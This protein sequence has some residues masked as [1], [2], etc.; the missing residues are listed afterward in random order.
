MSPDRRQDD[1]RQGDRRQGE[2]R[3]EERRKSPET[4]SVS[5]SVFV[6]TII[7]VIIVFSISLAL[8]LSHYENTITELKMQLLP[9]LTIVDDTT[10]D[11]S[12]F[13]NLTVVE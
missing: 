10:N 9:E 12:P 3:K 1:R 6:I 8:I 2:R 5:T 13:D 7:I 11:A 4:K